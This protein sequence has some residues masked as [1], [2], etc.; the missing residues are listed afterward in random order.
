VPVPD[1]AI[2]RRRPKRLPD[3]TV[4]RLLDAEAAAVYCGGIS[5]SLFL[6]R[7]APY[8]RSFTIGA[9]RLYDVRSIDSWV[10]AK[11]TP[12]QFSPTG[13]SWVGRLG[14]DDRD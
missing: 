13:S 9:R 11:S 5:K 10:D 14:D 3:G 12:E 8:V 6:D 2:V 1:P 4:P 7:V